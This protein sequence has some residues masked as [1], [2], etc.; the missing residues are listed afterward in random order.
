MRSCDETLELISAALD[1]P[2]TG[3]EQASLDEHLSHCPACSA[4]FEEL[5]GLQAA[6]AELGDVPAPVGFADRVMDAIAADPAQEQPDN[7]VP[8]PGKKKR[9]RTPWKGW[10]ATAAVVAVVVL[11]AVTLPGQF[12]AASKNAATGSS[13]DCAAPASAEAAD[14]APDTPMDAGGENGAPIEDRSS[15][16]MNVANAMPE[17]V[18]DRISDE[19]PTADAELQKG[20]NEAGGA[21]AF[22]VTG[23]PAPSCGTI[24]L[25]GEPLPDGLEDY[26]YTEDEEGNR[27]YQV[28]ADYFFSN[29]ESLQAQQASNFIYSPDQ[30]NTDPD[31]EYGLII[32]EV[33]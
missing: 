32:V 1:G 25:T 19:E 12:G 15:I 7:V 11:G 14:A 24:T 9:A 8:F 28:P 17:S 27:T 29:V 22:S 2:L 23:S 3:E 18:P 13:A 21:V 5:C 6:A 4:L 16:Q 26:E 31:A 10:A 33:P 20:L 30:E